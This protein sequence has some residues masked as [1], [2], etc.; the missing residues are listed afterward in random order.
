QCGRHH[1]RPFA[2]GGRRCTR[3][4]NQIPGGAVFRNYRDNR[5]YII[6]EIG[7]NF[8][9]LHDARR[10]ADEAAACGV[11]AVKLQTYRADTLSS[12]KAMFDMENTGKTSQYELFRKYEI[13]EKLHREV[14]AYAQER[15]LDWFST[16]S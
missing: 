2:C 12:R 8:P 3:S 15:N 7:G 10:L 11:D 13:D 9:T 1:R 5:C 6:A 4:R 16:P 14:F